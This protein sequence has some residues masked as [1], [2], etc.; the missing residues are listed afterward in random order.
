MAHILGSQPYPRFLKWIFSGDWLSA[1]RR[2]TE[3]KRAGRM[4]AS[5]D[6]FLLF[7]DMYLETLSQ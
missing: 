1:S 5:P 2:Q 7:E 6:S 3:E 4:A